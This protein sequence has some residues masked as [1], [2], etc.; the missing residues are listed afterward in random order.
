MTILI[1]QE[2]VLDLLNR[3][4]FCVLFRSLINLFL[5]IDFPQKIDPMNAFQ[6]DRFGKKDRRMEIDKSIGKKKMLDDIINK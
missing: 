2:W 6:T 4:Y 1:S 3:F 5:F